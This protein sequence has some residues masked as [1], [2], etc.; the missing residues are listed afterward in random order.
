MATKPLKVI[1][2]LDYTPLALPSEVFRLGF[3][4]TGWK[5]YLFAVILDPSLFWFQCSQ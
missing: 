4:C 3:C 2:R 1:S 5:A